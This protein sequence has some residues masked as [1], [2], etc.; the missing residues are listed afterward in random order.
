MVDFSDTKQ[1]AVTAAVIAEE[2]KGRDVVVIDFSGRSVLYDYVIITSAMSKTE[3][4]AIAMAIDAQFKNVETHRRLIQGVDSG[5]WVLLDYGSIVIHIFAEQDREFAARG[6]RP[7]NRDKVD[8]NYRLFYDL[9]ELWKDIPRLDYTELPE[10][11][12]IREEYLNSS[13]VP[14]EEQ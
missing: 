1:M 4:R 14:S 8:A 5:F 10:T 13:A 9:E 12:K 2:K 11:K 6:L 3:T 7:V